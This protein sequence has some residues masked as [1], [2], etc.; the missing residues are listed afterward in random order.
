[1]IVT[2]DTSFLSGLLLTVEIMIYK[3]R[4][5]VVHCQ[6]CV[7]QCREHICS[8]VPNVGRAFIHCMKDIL[9]MAAVELEETGFYHLLRHILAI[10]ADGRTSGANC[11]QHDLDHFIYAVSIKPV[12]LR[13][14]FKLKI[15]SDKLFIS[16]SFVNPIHPIKID[17]LI[18]TQRVISFL[19]NY[20][21]SIYLCRISL[22][23][24]FH[25]WIIHI[26]IFH[27]WTARIW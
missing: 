5:V 15:I 27:V 8:D 1:M 26:G 22:V 18:V 6:G 2:F 11:V 16:R 17:R 3:S 23:W 13:E 14:Y 20:L 24:F 10:D 4:I 21:I 9:Y 7:I 12:I 19:S 25:V